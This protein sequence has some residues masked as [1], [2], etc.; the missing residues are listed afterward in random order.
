MMVSIESGTLWE[1]RGFLGE[2][3]LGVRWKDW[4]REMIRHWATGVSTLTHK[5]TQWVYVGLGCIVARCGE[6]V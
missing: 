2:E 3:V 5:G 4:M 1:L 6:F